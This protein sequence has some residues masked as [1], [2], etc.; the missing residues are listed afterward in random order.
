[1]GRP[2]S[3]KKDNFAQQYTEDFAQNVPSG[4]VSVCSSR[5]KQ[6]T[7]DKSIDKRKT[8][9]EVEMATLAIFM[10]SIQLQSVQ[11]ANTWAGYHSGG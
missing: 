5:V 9:A 8:E 11:G 6:S 4:T 7:R 2:P 3:P 1:M 10:P